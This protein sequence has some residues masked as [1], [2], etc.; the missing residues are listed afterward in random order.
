MYKSKK[1]TCKQYG[2][3]SALNELT[4][5]TD[6]LRDSEN[7]PTITTMLEHINAMSGAILEA[8]KRL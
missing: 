7:T 3:E 5:T 2:G 6:E 8:A 4:K 1:Y